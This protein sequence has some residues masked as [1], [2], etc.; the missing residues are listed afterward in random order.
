MRAKEGE[1]DR[2]PQPALALCWRALDPAGRG[3]VR[4]ARLR[5]LL[6][7]P[8][9]LPQSDLAALFSDL[10]HCKDIN[11]DQFARAVLGQQQLPFVESCV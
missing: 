8:T 4:S 3:T 6:G 1:P 2:D 7:G 10:G 9:G 11:Y 5:L